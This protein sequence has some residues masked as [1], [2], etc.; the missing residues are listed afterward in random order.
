MCNRF[1]DFWSLRDMILNLALCDFKTKYAGSYF[2]II[3]A[4]VQ[5]MMMIGV[6]WFVFEVGFRAARISDVPF[7][8]WLACGL[9]PWFFFSEAWGSTTNVYF[10]YAYL[11]KKVLFRISI[12]PL[13]KITSAFFVHCVF[14]VFLLTMFLF[15]GYWPDIY[16]FQLLY[17]IIC[18]VALIGGVSLITSS[19]M[20]FFRD[21]VQFLNIVLQFGMWMTPI[22][23]DYTMLDIKYRWILSLNPVFYIVEGFRNTLIDKIW[24]WQKP[25]EFLIFWCLTAL[26][27]GGGIYCFKR[28]KPYF[29]DVL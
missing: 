3:W 25:V 2:G 29:S 22:M 12:L 14:V 9:I 6:F 28:T 23:W 15:Y 11:V 24:F 27:L 21:I 20:P 19:L 26:L 8:L 17:Y 5:P 16:T 10:E 7:I 13:I 4:F 18:M 1:K